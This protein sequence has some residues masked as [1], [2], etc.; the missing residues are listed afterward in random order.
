LPQAAIIV[1]LTRSN[2]VSA[3]LALPDYGFAACPKGKIYPSDDPPLVDEPRHKR[4][5]A[6]SGC[7]IVPFGDIV[8]Y[9][10]PSHLPGPPAAPAVPFGI[11][12]LGVRSLHALLSISGT[13]C[14]PQFGLKRDWRWVGFAVV[15]RIISLPFLLAPLHPLASFVLTFVK[16]STDKK[17]KPEPLF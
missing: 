5:K 9:V 8:W 4:M 10:T 15:L 1:T 6:M 17:I 16:V 13:I 14:D 12:L 7:P 11:A 3:P 2:D